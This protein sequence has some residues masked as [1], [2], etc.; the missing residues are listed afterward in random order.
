MDSAG[1]LPKAKH[2]P[3]N[4]SALLA[5]LYDAFPNEKV[6]VAEL[7]DRLEGRAIGLLLLILALPMC[8]P[9]VPGISTIFGVLLI[10]PGVQMMLGGGKL[11]LPRRVR[12]W[13]FSRE[14]LQRAIQ[15]ANPYLKRIERLIR[16]RWSFLTRTPFTFLFGFQVL[17]MAFVLVLPIPFGNWPPAMTLAMMALALLQRDGILMLL[18]VPAGVLSIGVAYAGVRIGWAALVELG[19]ILASFFRVVTG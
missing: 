5:E 10:A 3:P 8:I 1:A 9:N 14:G 7:I 19:E 16:P 2:P 15:V 13:S 12:A 4:A 11:W 18:S 6:T 17:V